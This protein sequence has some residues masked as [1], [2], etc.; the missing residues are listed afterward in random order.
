MAKHEMYS[1][2]D[3]YNNYNQV[4]MAKEDKKERKN[5]N[6]VCMHIILCHLNYIML[7]SHFK[8]WQSKPL[9]NT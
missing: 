3:G 2:M 8:K 6:G 4:K 7:L 5:Q 1:F 9:R